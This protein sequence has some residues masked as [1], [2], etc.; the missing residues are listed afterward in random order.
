MTSN[1]TSFT[2]SCSSFFS[3]RA[4]VMPVRTKIAD[5]RVVRMYNILRGVFVVFTVFVFVFVQRGFVAPV[6]ILVYPNAWISRSPRGS[7]TPAYCD[8]KNIYYYYSDDWI[9]RNI[10][11]K[12]VSLNGRFIKYLGLGNFFVPTMITEKTFIPCP[13]ERE[14]TAAVA[15]NGNGSV[16][17]N[18]YLQQ[19]GDQR[20][21]FVMWAEDSEVSVEIGVSVP[22]L[23]FDYGSITTN[24]SVA[25]IIFA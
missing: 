10:T 2:E 14:T 8:N 17:R 12:P 21:S 24:L 5:K 19:V 6:E 11:C 20:H 16:C 4:L 18:G 15:Q 1:S 25:S 23:N 22:G 13:E 3:C 9:Y 7:D